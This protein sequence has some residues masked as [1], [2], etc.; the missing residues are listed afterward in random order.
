[1]TEAPERR[2]ERLFFAAE[3][4]W[5]A[6]SAER[7]L[8]LLATAKKLA[9][10]PERRVDIENLSGH[11]AMRRGAVMR[12]Y[13]TL[14][15]AAEAIE[16]VDRVKAIRILADAALSSF[17]AGHPADTLAAARRALEL[18]TPTD[19]PESKIFAHV[20]FGALAILAGRGSEGPDR[21]HESVALFDA[22]PADSVDP[23]LL[24][25]EC[26]A[27]LFLREV[28]AGRDLL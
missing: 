24:T 11:I 15:A 18:L 12:G 3:N 2:A 17:G 1:M 23:L 25:C 21:L 16:S 9:K 5:L 4:R 19:S 14:T 27:G 28:R 22:A 13:A 10:S 6:G 7:A 26:T 20:A 8:E